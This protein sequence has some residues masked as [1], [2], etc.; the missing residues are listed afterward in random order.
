MPDQSRLEAYEAAV[1]KLLAQNGPMLGKELAQALPEIPR[2]QLW[3]V[4][5]SSEQLQISHFAT[6]YLR[7][8]I[9]REDEVRLSP[10]ILRDFLS[11]TLFS[12]PNQR[13]KLIERQGGISNLHREIS[14]K[15]IALARQVMQAILAQ[16]PLETKQYL[17]AFI[18]G[19]LAYFLA[20]DEPREVQSIGEIVRGSD[21]DIIIVH[22]ALPQAIIDMI[23]VEMRRHKLYFLRHPDHRQELDY[24]CKSKKKMYSQLRY[25]DI[26][27]KIASKIAYE[28]MFLGGS[29][30][31][32]MS[33]R[34]ELVSSGVQELIE[35]DFQK[36]LLQR[37]SAMRTLIGIPDSL[38]DNT[39][40][41]FYFS[42]ERVEFS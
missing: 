4:C 23:E 32:Y 27:E 31:L 9:T 3:Q 8:D 18:A 34:D 42:Q 35:Q 24:I 13:R 20:H 38:D 2:L 40:S 30:E 5:F 6:Y 17:C 22:D 11:F 41:L 7:Y 12:L 25:G 36:A 19:D 15:K 16:L 28:S 14:L 39:R 10:S 33:V 26:H 29:L 37:R 1:R 21:I